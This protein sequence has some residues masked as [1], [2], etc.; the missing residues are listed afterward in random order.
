M[1]IFIFSNNYHFTH[2]LSSPV[3]CNFLQIWITV[4]LLLI[5]LVEWCVKWK[6]KLCNTDSVWKQCI[7][8]PDVAQ[9][10]YVQWWCVV[11]LKG[12]CKILVPILNICTWLLLLKKFRFSAVYT[13]ILHRFEGSFGAVFPK[14]SCSQTPFGFEN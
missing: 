4:S 5:R 13:H 8:L 7:I 11:I 3:T 10:V 9:F 12:Q 6:W 1:K 2:C 14:H